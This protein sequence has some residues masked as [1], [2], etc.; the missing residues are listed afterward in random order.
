MN[1][2]AVIT[3]AG[4]GV[5]R[6]VTLALA[7][8]GWSAVIS[9]RRES[10]LHET[11]EQ[12]G[13][14]GAHLHPVRC[15]VCSEDEVSRLMAAARK[16]LGPI[17]VLVNS[18]GV[19]VPNR[20][21]KDLSS[22]D[23]QRILDTNLNGAFFCIQA[24]LPWMREAGSGTIVNILSDAARTARVV[25]GPAYVAAKFGLLGVTQAINGEERHNGIRACAILPGEIN[26]SLLDCRPDPPPMAARETMLSADDVAACVLLAVQLPPRAIVEELLIRPA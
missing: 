13:D 8:Q 18:A 21:F 9:G 15:D 26:T 3:G 2:T 7:R 14:L 24:V 10:A 4:S 17:E 22:S 12:A 23:Y 6:A 16:K 1:Q 11:L 25:S 19:N 5:G 20:A